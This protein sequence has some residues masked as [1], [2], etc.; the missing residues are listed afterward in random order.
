MKTKNADQFF[1][2]VCNLQTIAG[3]DSFHNALDLYKRLHRIEA[4][5]SRIFTDECNG[6]RTGT[7]EEQ[8]K[9]DARILKSVCAL[10]PSLK[11]IFLNGDPRGYAL[12]IKSEEQ[13]ELRDKGIN[14]YSDFGGYGILAPEF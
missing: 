14:L 3:L 10:L 12:K 13:K 1:R 8:E 9:Q 7:E 2:H 11:T 4:R 5:C 6:T